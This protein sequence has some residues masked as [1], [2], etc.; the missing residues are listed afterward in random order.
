MKEE[1]HYHLYEDEVCYKCEAS[2]RVRFTP[3][4]ASLNR[5][6]SIGTGP[7]GDSAVTSRKSKGETNCKKTIVLVI[8]FSFTAV[9]KEERN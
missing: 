7:G 6:S 5:H 3:G 4:T 1:P 2:S 8:G 9:V